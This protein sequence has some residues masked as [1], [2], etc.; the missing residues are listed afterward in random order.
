M[1]ST[2][3]E[4][5]YSGKADALRCN[6]L[7]KVTATHYQQNT[8]YSNQYRRRYFMVNISKAFNFIQPAD[9]CAEMACEKALCKCGTEHNNNGKAAWI[10]HCPLGSRHNNGDEHPSL[11][12]W[13]D[14]NNPD[15]RALFKC[16]GCK[17]HPTEIIGALRLRMGRSA[18]HGS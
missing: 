3:E 7:T 11:E 18:I 16:Y 5:D 6:N 9:A 2:A 17:A 8:F 4:D 1:L 14:D 13:S 12:V 15:N 10:T